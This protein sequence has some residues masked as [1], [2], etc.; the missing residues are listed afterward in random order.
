V[1]TRERTPREPGVDASRTPAAPEPKQRRSLTHVGGDVE[2]GGSQTALA[3]KL[4]EALRITNS[5]DETRTHVHG[6]HTYPARLHPTTARLIIEGCSAPGDTV[7]DP[8]CGSGTVLVEAR[9][10][11]RRA[12]GVDVNPLSVR[13]SALK[14]RGATQDELLRFQAAADQVVSFAEE[15]RAAKAGP[16]QLYGNEDREIFAV[17]TLLELDSLRGGIAKLGDGAARRV[18]ELV[19]SSIL[20]KLSNRLSDSSQESAPR[21]LAGGFAIRIF[22]ERSAELLRQI[23]EFSSL[24]PKSKGRPKDAPYVVWEGDARTLQPVRSRSVNLV[25]CSPPYPGVY[26]YFDHHAL[27]LRWLG[28]QTD[29]FEACEIGAKRRLTPHATDARRTWI[30]D[31]ARVCAS[32]ERVLLP[33]GYACVVTADCAVRDTLLLA[34]ECLR[35]AAARAKL[36]VLAS[37]AQQRPHFHRATERWF[38]ER[39]RREHLIALGRLAPG[40]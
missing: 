9:L 20:V 10:A 14:C 22:K 19:L 35:E 7:L 34:D 24:L 29:S 30:A 32:I 4:A 11:G 33:G 16:L 15:R 31:L 25:V 28:L 36:Q 39:P 21:R 38:R 2:L 3:E 18:L 6:F 40:S 27:R 17:H 5:E 1:T 12:L 23:A 8:F 13:L 26:D 37:A